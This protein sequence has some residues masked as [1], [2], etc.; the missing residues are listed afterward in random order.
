MESSKRP[1]DNEADSLRGLAPWVGGKRVLARRIIREILRTPH[2][3]YAEPFIGMGG[4]FL[5]R[6]RRATAEVIND[7]STDVVNLFRIVQ[8]HPDALFAELAGKIMSRA[9]FVRL[10]RLDPESL[11]DIE[12]AARFIYLQ[13][14]GFGGRATGR[15]F[16]VSPR[17]P[18]GFQPRRVAQ[19]LRRVH[20]RLEGVVIEGLDA[21]AFLTRYDRP[22]TLF[23]LDPPYIG[24]EDIYGAE[25]FSAVDHRRIADHLVE[26][27]GAFVLS[28]NDCDQARELFGRWRLIEVEL[29]YT[30]YPESAGVRRRELIVCN[31]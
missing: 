28:I 29:S 19:L 12:R 21:G 25:L 8:R 3:C 31:R 15:S 2:Q 27:K 23:Y 4:V 10:A 11:T 17:R 20:E 16:A 9:E 13:Y 24:C 1:F 7:A 14:A 6:P 18:A 22:Y 26:L 30:I 5:R